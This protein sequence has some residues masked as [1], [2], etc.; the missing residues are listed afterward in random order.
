MS[1]FQ[2]REFERKGPSL[3]EYL[4]SITNTHFNVKLLLHKSCKN[5]II[6]RLTFHHDNDNEYESDN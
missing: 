3:L 1:L 6:G 4:V 2:Y 5:D